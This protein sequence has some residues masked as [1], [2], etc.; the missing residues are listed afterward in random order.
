MTKNIYLRE[1]TNQH[2]AYFDVLSIYREEQG[3]FWDSD[4]SKP[5]TVPFLLTCAAALE[6]CLNDH[7]IQHLGNTFDDH[8]GSLLTQGFLSMSLKGKLLHVVP[9]LTAQKF[10]IN[11]NHKTYQ[12]LAE[13]IRLR[14]SLVHNKSDFQFHEA[15][16]MED[17]DGNPYIKISDDFS[18]R[19]DAIQKGTHDLTFGVKRN[20]TEFHDALEHFRESFFWR[21]TDADYNG[22]EL[23]V[24]LR[25][26]ELD[27]VRVVP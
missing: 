20:V 7:A 6:C 25:F 3:W 8:Q 24:S 1:F 17:Q 26:S 16:V 12:T 27:S 10:M 5:H 13:L 4:R 15:Q 19:L 14:N 2:E 18:D 23:I 9:L 22:S 21:F 11:T